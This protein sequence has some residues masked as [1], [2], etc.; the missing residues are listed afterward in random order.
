[1]SFIAGQAIFRERSE[2]SKPRNGLVAIATICVV[3][4]VA[5]AFFGA[6]DGRFFASTLVTQAI[7]MWTGL[8]IVSQMFLRRAALTARW[9]DRAFSVAFRWFA[10]P[11]LTLIFVGVAHFAWIEGDHIIPHEIAL[12]PVVYLLVTGVVLWLR[13]V[14]VFGIDN[15]SLMYVYFPAESRLVS[16]NVYGALRHPIYSAVLR[17]IFALV[18]WNGSAFALFAGVMA[19]LSMFV[20]VRAVEERELIERLGDGYRDYRR[21][22]PAFFNLDPRA[23]VALWR[24]LV[25]GK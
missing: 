3:L 13:A 7:V 24:F 6:V 20:W 9:G 21:R 15:L 18:L 17:F 19:P 14:F 11:G 8:V 1:M 25:R 2:L 5:I 16:S 22:V 10:V 12:V 4:L 23:W